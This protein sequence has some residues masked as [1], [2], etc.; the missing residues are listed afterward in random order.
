MDGGPAGI[1]PASHPVSAPF[2]GGTCESRANPIAKAYAIDESSRSATLHLLPQLGSG[3]GAS[4]SLERLRRL[5]EEPQEG[6]SHP[7]G[8]RKACLMRDPLEGVVTTF[9]ERARHLCAQSFDRACR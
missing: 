8:I 3:S 4:S 6:T 9:D 5:A 1:E 2:L 7:L